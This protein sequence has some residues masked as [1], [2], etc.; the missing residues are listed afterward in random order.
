VSI[1]VL[2]NKWH[3]S[4]PAMAE[5]MALTLVMALRQGLNELFRRS[6]PEAAARDSLIGHLGIF[7][8]IL[9]GFYDAQV[10]DGA[11]R[12]AARAG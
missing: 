5:T 8:G 7:T 12:A 6:I 9:F 4:K 1:A 10:S 11:K 2:W 3:C